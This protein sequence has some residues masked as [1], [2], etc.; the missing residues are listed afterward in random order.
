M[1]V[2]QCTSKPRLSFLEVRPALHRMCNHHSLQIAASVFVIADSIYH[3]LFLPTTYNWAIFDAHAYSTTRDLA[4]CSERIKMEAYQ[5]AA[6]LPVVPTVATIDVL[7][8]VVET[9]LYQAV[10]LKE[11]EKLITETVASENDKLVTMFSNMKLGYD[12]MTAEV[13]KMR[14]AHEKTDSELAKLRDENTQ[15]RYENDRLRRDWP[16]MM[17]TVQEHRNELKGIRE[18]SCDGIFIWRLSAI[19]ELFNSVGVDPSY[20]GLHINSMAFYSER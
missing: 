15:M 13:E 19:N 12:R 10:E 1:S 18:G 17:Y 16:L 8:Q 2:I 6:I 20:A 11:L 14:K 5:P 9:E 4:L 3:N 7:E